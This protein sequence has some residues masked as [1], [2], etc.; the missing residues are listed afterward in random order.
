MAEY[1]LPD[2][3]YGNL[4]SRGGPSC[5]LFPGQLSARCGGGYKDIFGNEW[6]LGLSISFHLTSNN[7]KCMYHNLIAEHNYTSGCA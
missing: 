5:N 7:L 4:S 3:L 1:G 2:P 6:V